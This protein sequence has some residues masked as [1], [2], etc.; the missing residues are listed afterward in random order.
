MQAY[1]LL[2]IPVIYATATT[3]FAAAAKVAIIAALVA[4]ALIFWSFS[5]YRLR[6]Y[7]IPQQFSRNFEVLSPENPTLVREISP[8]LQIDEHAIRE[9]FYMYDD[10]VCAQRV[11]KIYHIVYNGIAFAHRVALALAFGLASEGRGKVQVAS[12]LAIYSCCIIYFTLSM[13][14]VSRVSNACE[15]AVLLCECCILSF[16]AILLK[17]GSVSVQNAIVAFY[18]VHI[19]LSTVPELAK[20]IVGALQIIRKRSKKQR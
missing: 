18:F 7:F 16:A 8:R 12:L 1:S 6:R 2:A 3:G 4:P 20:V 5:L 15:L 14:F 10:L 19:A 17:N 13:P 11:A 9:V